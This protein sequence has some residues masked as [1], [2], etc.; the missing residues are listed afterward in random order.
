[1]YA[2]AARE[3]FLTVDKRACMGLVWPFHLHPFSLLDQKP[4]A[5]DLMERADTVAAL[6]SSSL[7]FWECERV[8]RQ[9]DS[10]SEEAAA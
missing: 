3:V 1:M 2:L 4:C 9:P 8:G 5:V 6:L 10:D 7:L